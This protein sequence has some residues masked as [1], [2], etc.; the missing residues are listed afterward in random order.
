M[1]E[2][3]AY[4]DILFFAMVA[5]FIALRLRSVLGRRTGQER[6]RSGGFGP[7]RAPTAPRTT[8][9]LCR[10]G[11][12]HPPR[13]KRRRRPADNGVEAGLAQIRLADQRFDPQ[14]FLGGA[15]A[16]FEMIVEAFAQGDNAALRPL[17][18]DDV[19]DGF[20]RRDPRAP[21]G[22][23]KHE[24][25]LTAV[26]TAE[27]VE[28]EMRGGDARITVRFVT[29]QVNVTRDADGR[30]IDGIR[31]PRRKSPICGRSRATP[32]PATRTGPWSR[33]A[34][35]VD[36]PRPVWPGAAWPSPARR[37]WPVREPE[38]PQAP[39]GAADSSCAP[40][41]SPSCPA[42]PRTPA[43]GA[44][45][46][47]PLVRPAGRRAASTALAPSPLAP[48]ATGAGV[49]RWPRPCRHVLGRQAR[50]FVEDSLRALS[51]PTAA[52]PEGLFTGYYEPELA[53][54]RRAAAATRC[55]SIAG[56]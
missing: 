49:R 46:A 19:Y 7:A 25:P 33:P 38:P 6:R 22:R 39:A 1:S 12:A 24:T 51:P 26:P 5:A 21:D 54:R 30:V 14:K 16:A 23:H 27:V 11:Q 28:R 56:R 34:R 31:R 35:P 47:P 40:S 32:A 15:R 37:C 29:E 52:E 48:P 45:R 17:L 13:S 42:G 10:T 43:R 44:R 2:G 8:W 20:E 41:R 3:F 36:A 9:W 18:A 53:A 55:R 50:A 4:I